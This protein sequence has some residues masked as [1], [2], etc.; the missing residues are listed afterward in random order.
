MY[1][2]CNGKLHQMC[3]LSRGI[4]HCSK[5]SFYQGDRVSALFGMDKLH[6]MC[7]LSRGIT[8]LLLKSKLLPGKSCFRIIRYGKVWYGIVYHS[9][10]QCS[11][12]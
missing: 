4:T 8:H 3:D 12:V 9:I 7:D 5:V 10:V 11:V 2:L 6:Q 1:G